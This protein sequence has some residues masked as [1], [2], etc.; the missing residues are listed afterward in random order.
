MS[1]RQNRN[2]HKIAIW[3]VSTLVTMSIAGIIYLRNGIFKPF[4]LEEPAY[5][6]I[7]NEKNFEDV[8]KQLQEKAGLPSEKIVSPHC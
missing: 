3:I 7:D 1:K 4:Q 5:I 2:S 8:I 6:Y